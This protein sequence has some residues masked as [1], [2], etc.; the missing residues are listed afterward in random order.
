MDERLSTPTIKLLKIACRSSS[1]EVDWSPIWLVTS[2][3]TTKPHILWQ[4]ICFPMK[5]TFVPWLIIV[6]WSCEEHPFLCYKFS[7]CQ[8]S[9]G[10]HPWSYSKRWVAVD[11]NVHGCTVHAYNLF[12]VSYG[13]V[14][15]LDEFKVFETSS[16]VKL[17]NI[18]KNKKINQNDPHLHTIFNIFLVDEQEMCLHV[19]L[20]LRP[21]DALV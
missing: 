2:Q 17:I 18:Y 1:V 13:Y 20:S 14:A 21:R 11:F 15:S 7:K 4:K 16:S 3:A 19:F 8:D 6:E 10:L 12:L 5:R 9:L